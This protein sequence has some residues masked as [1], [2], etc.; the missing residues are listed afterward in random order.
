MQRL[1]D[2]EILV[3]TIEVSDIKVEKLGRAEIKQKV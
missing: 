3:T 2:R 1:Y